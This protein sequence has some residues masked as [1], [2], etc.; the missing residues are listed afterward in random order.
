MGNE[1][2][3]A[4]L[5]DVS[6]ARVVIP[7]GLYA[8]KSNEDEHGSIGTQIAD[9]RRGVEEEGDIVAGAEFSA[10]SFKQSRPRS[11]GA[12]LASMMEPSCGSSTAIVSLW[13]LDARQG[14]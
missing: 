12:R 9:C 10:S 3:P 14:I 8:A 4:S 2:L 6:T 7:C 5:A 11:G 1:G 13:A